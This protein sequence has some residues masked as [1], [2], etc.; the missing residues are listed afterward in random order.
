MELGAQLARAPN[1]PL[2][3]ELSAMFTDRRVVVLT[4]IDYLLPVILVFDMVV[5]PFSQ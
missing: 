1:G 3:A 2:T 4:V 5:K